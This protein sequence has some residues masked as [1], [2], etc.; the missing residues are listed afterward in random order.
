MRLTIECAQ[1]KTKTV[2]Y[3]VR[4]QRY[5]EIS[6]TLMSKGKNLLM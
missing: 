2:K 5:A 3:I 1:L 4:L 6:I